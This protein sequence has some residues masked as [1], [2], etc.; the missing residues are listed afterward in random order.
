VLKFLFSPHVPYDSP[1]FSFS[2]WSPKYLV[3]SKN[4]EANPSEIFSN[5]V[6]PRPSGSVI[7][8]SVRSAHVVLLSEGQS[9]TRVCKNRQNY[10]ITSV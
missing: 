6:S 9:F 4:H 10:V 7:S 8:C 2:I 1:I 5:A 3:W